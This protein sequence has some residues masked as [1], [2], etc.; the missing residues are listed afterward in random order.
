MRRLR[1]H[2][3]TCGNGILRQTVAEPQVRT[4]RFIDEEKPPLVM[5]MLCDFI[6]LCRN[7]VISRIDEDSS[8]CLGMPLYRAHNGRWRNAVRNA[9]TFIHFRRKID[10]TGT[11]QNECTVNRTVCISLHKNGISGRKRCKKHRMY[12]A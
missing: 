6:E 1:R 5:K 10:R 4:V 7:A 9:E 2:V 8:L 3:R 12:C 11:K